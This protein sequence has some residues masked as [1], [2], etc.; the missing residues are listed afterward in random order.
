MI[1][2][3]LACIIAYKCLQ[4]LQHDF[5]TFVGLTAMVGPVAFAPDVTAAVALLLMRSR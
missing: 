5:C 3:L 2:Q 4:M 1:V